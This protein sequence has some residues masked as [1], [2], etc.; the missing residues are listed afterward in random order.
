MNFIYVTVQFL[1]SCT[2]AHIQWFGGMTSTARCNKHP[3]HG[4]YTEQQQ[5][6]C[7]ASYIVPEIE[8]LDITLPPNEPGRHRTSMNDSIFSGC[9]CIHSAATLIGTPAHLE[10]PSNHVAG[11]DWKVEKDKKMLLCSSAIQF[12]CPSIVSDVLSCSC[13]SSTST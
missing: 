8:W 12:Q 10:H 13:S 6:L 7:K 5:Q 1:L 11:T 9:G 4:N 3:R 2:E